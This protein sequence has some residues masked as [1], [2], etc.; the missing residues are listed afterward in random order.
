MA[1]RTV[2]VNGL[3]KSFAMTGWRFGYAAGPKAVIDAISDL[4]GQITSGPPSFVQAAAVAALSGSQEDVQRM[5]TAYRSRGERMH[6]LLTAIPGVRCHKPAGAFYC[7]PDVSAAFERL[8][9]ADAD[10][11]ADAAL[12]RAHVALVSGTAFGCP[13]HVRLSFATSEAQIDEG[14]RRLSKMMQG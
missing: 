7:F 13:T 9:V 10:G 4:Q 5:S 1:E 12:E 8:G 3:S 14:L 6:K 11:F 2:T